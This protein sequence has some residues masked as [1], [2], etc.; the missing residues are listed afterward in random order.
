[1][2]QTVAMEKAKALRAPRNCERYQ[3]HRAQRTCKFAWKGWGY[4]SRRSLRKASGVPG[5]RSTSHMA[6]FSSYSI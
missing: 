2:L 4:Y 3:V 5:K 6:Q 1:M